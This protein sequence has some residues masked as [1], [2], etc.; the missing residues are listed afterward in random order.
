MVARAVTGRRWARGLAQAGV[1]AGFVV[2]ALGGGACVIDV[3]QDP[4]HPCDGV[5]CSL[6]GSCRDGACYC[7]SGYLGNPYALHGCQSSRPGVGCTTTCGLN[8]Y[9]E[10][11]ACVCEQ[12]FLAVCG[13]GDCL[14]LRQLCDGV[15]DCANQADEAD[16]TC[17]QQAVQQW[18]LVDDC[19]DG[20]DIEWRL[21][22]RDRDWAWPGPDE[23][24]VTDDEGVP[25][26]EEVECLFGEQICLGAVAGARTWGVGVDGTGHCEGCCFICSEEPV[27][28]GG[29]SCE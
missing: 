11:G 1:L 27:D 20:R 24:F 2:G 18:T 12:G 16:E 9:C 4:E 3:P 15:P 7:D 8:A 13:T 26:H 6:N 29:L 22:S 10:D 28:L 23:A 25:S 17:A 14:A 19:D 21:W 5:R